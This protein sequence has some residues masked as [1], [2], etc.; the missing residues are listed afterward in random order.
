MSSRL[1]RSTVTPVLK[2]GAEFRTGVSME[3]LG[4]IMTELVERAAAVVQRYGGTVDSLEIHVD[5]PTTREIGTVDTGPARSLPLAV[6]V[7]LPDAVER[8]T[9]ASPA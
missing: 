6:G 4:E 7:L 2:F 9:S 3:L 8:S 1:T 5:G